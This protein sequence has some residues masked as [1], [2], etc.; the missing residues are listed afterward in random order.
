MESVV[1]KVRARVVGWV[2]DDF[3]G[4]LEVIVRDASGEEH[5]I[6]DKLPVLT[7]LPI[8]PGSPLPPEL[9][10]HADMIQAS[11]H[12]VEI[13]LGDDIETVADRRVLTVSTG[14]VIWI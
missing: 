14:D 8:G 6:V 3:P 7:S 4:W 13:A 9:W 1:I 11:A 2:S 10:L 12:Q 5:R